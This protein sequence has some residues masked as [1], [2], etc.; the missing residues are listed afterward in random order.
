MNLNLCISVTLLDGAFH[1]RSPDANEAEWPPSPYRLI[2]ALLAGAAQG[3]QS[4]SPHLL[5]ALRRLEQ[6]D[7]PTIVAPHVTKGSSHTLYVPNNVDDLLAKSWIK[8]NDLCESPP[9]SRSERVFVPLRLS[10][11]QTLHYIFSQPGKQDLNCNSFVEAIILIASRLHT[12]GTGI[13]AACGLA[14]LLDDGA[15]AALPGERYV[16]QSSSSV[17]G[18]RLRVPRVGL[19]DDLI[20]CH[21][22]F[23]DR[24]DGRR[25]AARQEPKAFDT[26]IYRNANASL[27]PRPFAAFHLLPVDPDDRRPRI[28]F[29]Q[30]RIVCVAAM[31]RHTAC[32]AA[33][34]DLDEEGWRTTAWA[35]Q[36][37]AGHGPHKAA[38]SFAR[39]SYL[40]IPTLDHGNGMVYRALVAETPGGDG[41]AARWAAQRIGGAALRDEESG[42]E[43]AVL[44]NV[45][46]EGDTVFRQ[47]L[48]E[49]DRWQT[50]TPIILPGFDDN[51]RGKA[52]KLLFKCFEQAR[53][54]REMIADWEMQKSPWSR[55]S[56]QTRN[57]LRTT[58]LEHLPAW[59]VRIYFIH[60]VSGPLAIGAG[61][62]RGLGLMAALD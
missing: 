10:G 13:D 41:R 18:S 28:S 54:P 59:H 52:S 4:C 42:R 16:P 24:V 44:R 39:F 45:Q 34:N 57:Y 38:E 26:R 62:H 60:R 1:G 31:L 56:A 35:D 3:D 21:A 51:D 12:L 37:V 15:I 23:L 11:G 55:A 33:L 22:S 17:A 30:E 43:V 49:S 46:P 6:L 8:G 14:Q 2:Q 27:P 32:E 36:F 53:I 9:F 48:K 58:R 50:I 7:P 20:A 5:D 40:P 29:R 25:S 19:L 61:R 47:F